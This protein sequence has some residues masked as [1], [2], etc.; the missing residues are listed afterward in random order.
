[1]KGQGQM[2]TEGN[3][4]ALYSL[5]WYIQETLQTGPRR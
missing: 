5:H 1:M 3:E 4:D 2:T